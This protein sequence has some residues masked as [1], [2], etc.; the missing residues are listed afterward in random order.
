MATLEAATA[1]QLNQQAAAAAEAEVQET[2]GSTIP[3]IVEVLR[4]RT[5][6]PRTGSAARL[7]ATLWPTAR[8]APDSKS[9]VRGAIWPAIELT[10]V[11]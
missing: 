2:G 4:I 3:S 10:V 7:A 6:L 1:P 8:L 9:A 11:A 5:E